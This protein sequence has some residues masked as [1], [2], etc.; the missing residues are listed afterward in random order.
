MTSAVGPIWLLNPTPKCP[1]CPLSHSCSWQG[2]SCWHLPPQPHSEEAW[3]SP[4]KVAGRAGCFAGLPSQ[5]AGGSS[6][7]SRE[8]L[9]LSAWNPSPFCCSGPGLEG[10]PAARGR[11]VRQARGPGA[12]GS[13]L[14]SGHSRSSAPGLSITLLQVPPGEQPTSPSPHN[15]LRGLSPGSKG[16]PCPGR[17]NPPGH[18]WL[19]PASHAGQLLA[20]SVQLLTVKGHRPELE[21]SLLR[22]RHPP[23]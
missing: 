23:G 15:G 18:P 1:L 6:R 12:A 11:A 10:Q 4:A 13:C 3:G 7:L 14:P 17:V 5:L 20:T 22:A 19:F 2:R 9:A 8:P 16:H 21:G